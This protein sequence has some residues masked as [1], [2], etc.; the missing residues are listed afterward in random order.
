MKRELVHVLI[1]IK[2]MPTIEIT[3]HSSC[4]CQNFPIPMIT[5]VVLVAYIAGLS[6]CILGNDLIE[7]VDRVAFCS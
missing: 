3:F 4:D 7:Q 2:N 5:P 1:A 6:T